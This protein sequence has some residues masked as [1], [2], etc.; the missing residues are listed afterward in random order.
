MAQ[1]KETVVKL[2]STGK[3]ALQSISTLTNNLQLLKS[4]KDSGGSH[5]ADYSTIQVC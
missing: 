4:I 2:N 5:Q 1:I 3:V